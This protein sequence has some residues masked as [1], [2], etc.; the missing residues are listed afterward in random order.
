MENAPSTMESAKPLEETPN[1]DLAVMLDCTG[2]M[3][4]YI[5]M[6]QKKIKDIISQVKE[7]YCKSEIRISIVAYRDFCDK[8]RFEIL[9]FTSSLNDAKIFLDK[10]KADGGGDTPEDVN[11]A[12]QKALFE[13]EWKSTVRLLVHIADAPCHGKKFHNCDDSFPDG[14]PSDFPW[15]KIFERLVE[16]RIDYLFLK[17]LDI[18]NKMFNLFSEIAKEKGFDKYG[19]TFNQESINDKKEIAAHG[20]EDRFAITISEK[21][22]SCVEKELKK[23][24]ENRLEK[25]TLEN[26]SLVEN[27]KK[28]IAEIVQTYDFEALKNKYVDLSAKVGECILS[29]NNFIEALAD[30]DCLCLTFN[31]GRSQAAIVDPS[32]VIIKDVFPSFLTVGSFFYS[33]EFALKKNKL[34]HGG[35]IKNAEGLIIKGAAQEDITGVMP[36]YFCEE[37]WKVAKSLMKLAIGWAVTLEPTGYTYSQVKIVPFLIFAKMA[38]KLHEQPDSEFLKF[39]LAL[40]KETCMQIMKDGSQKSFTNKFD[41]EVS[42]L[43]SNYV[44]E[45]SLRTVDSIPN[46]IVFLAQLYIAK[47][48][49]IPVATEDKYFEIFI[50]GLIEEE[51]RRRLYPLDEKLNRNEWILDVLNVNVKKLIDEPLEKFKSANKKASNPIYEQLFLSKLDTSHDKKEE[52][53]EVRESEEIKCEKDEEESK[54]THN[55]ENYD[56]KRG[57]PDY[58]EMQRKVMEEQNKVFKKIVEYLYPL[59]KALNGRDVKDPTNIAS[60]SIDNDSK[61]FSLYIQNKLQTKNSER[62]ETFENKKHRDPWTEDQDFIQNLCVNTIE[63]EKTVRMNEYL[64]AMKNKD[65]DEK[66]S[67]FAYSENLEEAAGSLIGTRVGDTNFM[68][69]FKEICKGKAILIRDKMRML[70]SGKYRGI[71]LFSGWNIGRKNV[72]R[73]GRAFSNEFKLWEIFSLE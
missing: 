1:V 34:A 57:N 59:I 12:F 58:N 42:N 6:C 52:I 66:A 32:Q 23:C 7:A 5:Q 70:I 56:F 49:G 45:T 30:E 65:S 16:L 33:T 54:T 60:W 10:L 69:Y 9:S 71:Q 50:K 24:F 28:S 4:S 73:F 29:S 48:C 3:G 25:R 15:E 22:K 61:F 38:Q 51:L 37:N 64:A 47:E 36:L 63:K 62:R 8:N 2:S 72:N 27:T 13:I 31:I 21:V 19:L 39:Q 18:T 26:A 55:F 43:Y 20:A 40:V 35:Y 17:V 46:N 14:H 68:H 67:I 41:E 44:K 53:K 11:G